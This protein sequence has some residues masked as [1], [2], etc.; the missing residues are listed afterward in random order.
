[1]KRI[2]S[3]ILIF[4]MLTAILQSCGADFIQNEY[5][6]SDEKESVPGVLNVFG[7]EDIGFSFLYPYEMNVLW[8][9]NDGACISSGD[10]K[11]PYVLI[12]K[13]NNRFMT[14]EWYFKSSD[15]QILKEFDNV[16]SSKIHEVILDGKTLYM[17]RY[18]CDMEGQTVYIDR[19]VEIYPKYC[20]QYTAVSKTAEEM[21]TVLYYAATTLSPEP[22][23]YLGEYTEEMTQ[24]MQDDTGLAIQIPEML[25]TRELTIGYI[26]AGT[27]AI[28]LTVLCTEDDL[29][30]PI[31][32]RQNF[33]DRAEEEPNFVA[34]YIG[35]DSTSF[36]AGAKKMINGNEFYAYSMTMLTGNEEF[37]GEIYLANADENG[38]IVVCYAV[39]D[40]SPRYDALSKLLL[41]AVNSIEY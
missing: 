31:Y 22:G 20:I 12:N 32:N 24:F 15:R 11:I 13:T 30:N 3:L 4:S 29:G 1:M 39:K 8:N 37:K 9:D 23:R 18:Q 2:S 34:G 6:V 5:T 35:A 33:M 40:T 21:N 26:A 27:D 41:K 7:G 10:G 14:P 28:L 19:Y 17:T 38:C 16:K 36:G 25:E